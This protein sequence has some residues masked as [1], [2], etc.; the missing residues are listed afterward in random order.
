VERLRLGKAG[1][2]ALA[3]LAGATDGPRVD[4]ATLRAEFARRFPGGTVL[5]ARSGALPA[6]SATPRELGFTLSELAAR[7]AGLRPS[8]RRGLRVAVYAPHAEARVVFIPHP[9]VDAGAFAEFQRLLAR[10]SVRATL[11]V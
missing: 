6:A 2:T 3:A 1:R 10:A 5:D 11:D 4:E 9:R 8:R 7:A